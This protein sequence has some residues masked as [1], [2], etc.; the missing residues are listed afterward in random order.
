MKRIAIALTFGVCTVSQ[1]GIAQPRPP[2]AASQ[3]KTATPITL[4]KQE[5]RTYA[6]IVA[7]ADADGNEHVSEAELAA[8]VSRGVRKQAA[9]RFQRLDRNGDGRVVRAEVPSMLGARFQRFDRN[10]DGAFTVAELASVVE[11]QALARCHAAFARLDQDGDGMLS[12]LDG[13]QPTV[14]SER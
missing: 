4:A 7:W 1:R 3:A 10:S 5:Q 2:R 6:K 8:V 9:S 12:F 11:A 14:V 13:A